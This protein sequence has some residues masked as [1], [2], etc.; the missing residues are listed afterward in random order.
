MTEVNKRLT[1]FL[2]YFLLLIIFNFKK[3]K[4]TRATGVYRYV[5]ISDELA[6]IKARLPV[7]AV[8]TSFERV[9]DI[10]PLNLA[11]S[12]SFHRNFSFVPVHL[13]CLIKFSLANGLPIQGLQ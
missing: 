6:G 4:R 13:L 5:N 12:L 10:S 8:R 7:L 3:G 9:S 2:M 11:F 1:T